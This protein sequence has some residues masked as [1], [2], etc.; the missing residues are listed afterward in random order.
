MASLIGRKGLI[1]LPR[2]VR[3]MA[4]TKSMAHFAHGPHVRVFAIRPGNVPH[5]TRAGR[6][7]GE[8]VGECGM[9]LERT[10]PQG[11]RVRSSPCYMPR[12]LFAERT[13][14]V[15]RTMPSC[16]P[17]RETAQVRRASDVTGD[18]AARVTCERRA[19]ARMTDPSK[20]S[21]YCDWQGDV[22][23]ARIAQRKGRASEPKTAALAV[24]KKNIYI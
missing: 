19:V 20:A 3:V 21:A 22:M 7:D 6:V 12:V 10:G 18:L 15:P 9:N 11:A 24:Q 2:R 23:A 1:W 14:R 4:C 5:R 16:W 17:A 13:E 8:K